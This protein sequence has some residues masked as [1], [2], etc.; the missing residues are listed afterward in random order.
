MQF[1]P[2][3][4]TA[5]LMLLGMSRRIEHP[6]SAGRRGAQAR[7]IRPMRRRLGAVIWSW[8]WLRHHCEDAQPAGQSPHCTLMPA[9][10]NLSMISPL[11]A[12]KLL[13]ASAAKRFPLR[14]ET[15][16]S[17]KSSC[18]FRFVLSVVLALSNTASAQQ[19]VDRGE[20]RQSVMGMRLKVSPNGRYLTDQDGKPFLYLADTA[21]TLF[22]RLNHDE[23][24]EYLKNRQA[25]GFTVIQAYLLRGLD[26]PNLEGELTLIDRDPGKPN[27]VFFRNVDY[28]VNRVNDL[29]LVMGVV[30]SY[31]EHVKQDRLKEYRH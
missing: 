30:V 15:M 25:K 11:A 23:L 4:A 1:E 14:V 17:R 27:E 5:A 7:P 26:V 13:F 9:S 29:E 6:L 24:D 10:R 21:W 3:F 2:G 28:I 12:H 20:T 22:K 31:R 18:R 16:N 8:R 19:E